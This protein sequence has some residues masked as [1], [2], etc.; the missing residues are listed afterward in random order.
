MPDSL[1]ILLRKLRTV[2]SWSLPDLLQIPL[3]WVMLGVARA[4]ILVLPFRA[5]APCLGI[6]VRHAAFTPIL[7]PYQI[8]HA[9]RLRRLVTTTA[10][11]TPWESKC[12]VQALVGV[13]LL[14]LARIPYTCYFGVAKS[15][16]QTASESMSAH[17][18]VTA[19]SV[20]VTGGGASFFR[21]S[22]IMSYISPLLAI[23]GDIE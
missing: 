14:R 20:T 1:D 19:G 21:F 8:E 13:C 16:G 22:I 7:T 17:A 12:L 23:S 10:K 5:F 15:P 3:V 2:A 9:C 11:Y 6:P 4:G 18:W